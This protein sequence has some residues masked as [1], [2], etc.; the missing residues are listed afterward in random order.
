[1]FFGPRLHHMS[2]DELRRELDTGSPVLIDVREPEEFAAGRVPG[3]INL[4]V[5]SLPLAASGLDRHAEILVICRSGRRS[6]T[7]SKR[8]LKAGFT[9]VR[10]VQGGTAGW[11]G[12]LER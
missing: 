8:L 6:I 12:P 10:D 4:P 7:A 5:G 3:A 2:A 9:N 11:T 1:M